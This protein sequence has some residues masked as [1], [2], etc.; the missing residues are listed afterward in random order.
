MA[1]ALSIC[2]GGPDRKGLQ[3]PGLAWP[4][5]EGCTMERR[6][7]VLPPTSQKPSAFLEIGLSGILAPGAQVPW[8]LPVQSHSFKNK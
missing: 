3:E 4:G 5:A 8:A 7:G 1:K 6:H 2:T